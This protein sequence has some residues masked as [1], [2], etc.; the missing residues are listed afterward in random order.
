MSIKQRKK[1]DGTT[2]YDVTMEYGTLDGKRDRRRK[3]F[4]TLA[5]A[6]KADETAARIRKAGRHAGRLTLGEYVERYY[7]PPTSR[8]LQATT[9]DTYRQE[10]DLRILPLLGDVFLSELDRPTVQRMLDRC[11]TESVARKSLGLL[12]TILN[13]AIMDGF[14]EHNPALAKFA[15]PPKGGKRDN[16]A[17]LGTWEAI[18]EYTEAVRTDAPRSLQRLVMSGLC[19]GLR[20]EERYALDWEDFDL[21]AATLHVRGAYVTASQRHGGNQLKPT[22]TANS[23]RVLPW[24]PAFAYFFVSESRG[25]GPW[26]TNIRG[27]RLSPSTGRKM[28]MRYLRDHPQLERVTLENMRHSFAT[29]CLHEGMNVEDVSRFLG[30]SDI[31]TTYK[32]YVRPGFESMAA[33]IRSVTW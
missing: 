19:M 18:R 11:A 31:N 28:W 29:A 5:E 2:V 9:L 6:R 3:T 17:V 23:E 26:I 8:R 12:K 7:W 16:G 32:R 24:S 21:R 14:A 20:P 1:K 13:E 30:H 22:K 15:M 27:E 25:T 10:L 4:A 33:S